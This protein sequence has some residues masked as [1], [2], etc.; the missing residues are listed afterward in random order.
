[1][2][3]ENSAVLPLSDGTIT[4]NPPKSSSS[5]EVLTA[6]PIE[7]SQ[8]RAPKLRQAIYGLSREVFEAHMA[9]IL[10]KTYNPRSDEIA[11]VT[12]VD[13]TD[14]NAVRVVCIDRVTARKEAQAK[15]QASRNQMPSPIVTPSRGG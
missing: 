15:A 6:E 4:E 8:A 3:E 13:E 5:G 14:D 9:R 1:M 10:P 2:S 7:L 11:H 12:I